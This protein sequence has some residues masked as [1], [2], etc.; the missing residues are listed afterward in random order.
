MLT[1]KFIL[2]FEVSHPLDILPFDSDFKIVCNYIHVLVPLNQLQCLIFK[3]ILDHVI[4]NKKKMYLESNYQLLIYIRGKSG[5]RKSRAVK[6]IEMVI[7]LLKKKKD[8]GIS[9]PTIFVVNGI[10]GSMVHIAIRVNTWVRKTHR[11][12]VNI[13]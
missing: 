11:V 3:K 5:A 8:L 10:G 12:K 1:I 2:R 4:R 6:V 7:V 9:T 13:K